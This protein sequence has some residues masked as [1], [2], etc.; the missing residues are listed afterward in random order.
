M[1]QAGESTERGPGLAAGSSVCSGAGG[2]GWDGAGRL[3]ETADR[4]Q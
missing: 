4:L 3:A 2:E 1:V